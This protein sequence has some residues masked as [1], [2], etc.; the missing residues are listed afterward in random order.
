MLR[1]RRVVLRGLGTVGLLGSGLL[2]TPAKAQRA[3]LATLVFISKRLDASTADYRKWYIEHHAPDFLSYARPYLSRY[4]QD[5]VEKAY[6]GDV[7]FDC[8]S[9]FQYPSLEA[10]DA[11]QKLNAT[12]EAQRILAAHPKIGSKPGPHEDHG[13]PRTFS[14]D[15]RLLSG[16]PRAYDPP[17]TRKQAILIRRRGK[18]TQDAFAA[19]AMH[20]GSAIAKRHADR[21][22]LDLAVAEPDR[23]APMFDGVIQIWPKGTGA[24]GGSGD[25]PGEIEVVNTLDL[26]SYE[27]DLGKR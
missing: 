19:A 25:A 27:S 26:L 23:P 15:E 1:S 24:A 22:V 20:F 9:E 18:A 17:G 6:N 21:A 3:T 7:D 5:F 2:P 4:T 8:I 13:G 12:P 10:L 11:L 14:V 16:P